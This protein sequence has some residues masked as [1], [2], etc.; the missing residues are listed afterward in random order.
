MSFLAKWSNVDGA[1][2]VTLSADYN[3]YYQIKKY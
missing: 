2:T 1:K 3:Y